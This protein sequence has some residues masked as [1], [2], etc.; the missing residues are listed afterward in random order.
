MKHKGWG[1]DQS[2]EE[3]QYLVIW[4][5]EEMQRRLGGANREMGETREIYNHVSQE[6]TEF[7]EKNDQLLDIAES[8][9][10]MKM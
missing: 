2:V 9:N 8:S 10:E 5:L 4:Y 3:M 6:Q 7:W 1:S